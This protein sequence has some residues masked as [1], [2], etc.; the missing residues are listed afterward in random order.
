M[1]SVLDAIRDLANPQLV[2]QLAN[3]LGEPEANVQRGFTTSVTAVLAALASNTNDSGLMQRVTDAAKRFASDPAASAAGIATAA[4][5]DGSGSVLLDALLGGS[6]TAALSSAVAGASGLRL[7]S[8]I[9]LLGS[10]VPV[11]LAWIGQRMRVEGLDASGLSAWLARE[12]AAIVSVLPP[13]L[14]TLLGAGGLNI[15]KVELPN[16]TIPSAASLPSM[17]PSRSWVP[18]AIV[19]LIAVLVIAFFTLRHKPAETVVAQNGSIATDTSAH[20]AA[21]APAVVDS[22]AAS[23][24]A[25]ETL[26]GGTEL[27]VAPNG[28][29]AQLIHFIKDSSAH[30]NDTTWFNF[31]RLL[32][33]TGSATLKPESDAQL[34]LVAQI[35]Q[36]YPNV[37]ARIGGYTD[38]T[39]NAAANLKLSESRAQ[40][41]KSELEKLGVASGRLDAKGYG[42]QHPV[43]DNSTADGRAANR[44]IALRVTAK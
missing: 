39:G 20:M 32:F 41:V 1:A 40:N 28:I 4:T 12:R 6:G 37:K 19:G 18:A 29:E 44:R 43:G 42:D 26:P 7:E 31:D 33:E 30:V 2:S 27:N 10:S 34:R 38:N 36:A 3:R 9:A 17:S 5:A 35:F 11:A 23:G 15:P 13:S 24:M 21:P 25:H 16:I 8:A 22:S 14:G